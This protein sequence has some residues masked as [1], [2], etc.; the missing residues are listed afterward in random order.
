LLGGC[1]CDDEGGESEKMAGF[2]GGR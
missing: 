2:H 1:R